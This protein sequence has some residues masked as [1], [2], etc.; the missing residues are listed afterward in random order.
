M[1]IMTNENYDNTNYS[2]NYSGNRARD[3]ITKTLSLT[4]LPVIILTSIDWFNR[5]SSIF[6]NG[7]ERLMS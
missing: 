6:S 5:N 7:I 1:K 2:N 4:Y 3:L